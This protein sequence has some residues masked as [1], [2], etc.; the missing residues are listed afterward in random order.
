MLTKLFIII[1]SINLFFF[2][3][4]KPENIPENF[5]FVKGGTFIMGDT[6]GTGKEKLSPPHQETVDDFYISKYEATQQEWTAVMNDT[7]CTRSP[8]IVRLENNLPVHHVSW[9]EAVEFCNKKSKMDGLM[10]CYTIDGATVVCDFKAN[11]YRLATEAEWEYAA[12]GG[13]K[14]KN[15]IYSGS[16]HADEVAWC[17]DREHIYEDGIQPV[18]T[19]RPNELGIYDMSGNV[20]E[21][22]WDW[23]CEDNGEKASSNQPKAELN[24]IHRVIRSGNYF[25]DRELCTVFTWGVRLQT[26]TSDYNYI[27]LRLARSCL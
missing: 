9:L 5:V 1:V 23:Y 15:T 2:M 22:C 12:R 7:P 27:G 14:D 26:H 20:W 13:K 17:E 16:N 10:P 3:C 19:K 21:W 8:F 11:G 4:Q 6:F 18:G 24:R 25:D